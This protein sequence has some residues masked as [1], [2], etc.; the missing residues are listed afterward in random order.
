MA[1]ENLSLPTIPR[2][3]A[4]STPPDG[5]TRLTTRNGILEFS[6]Y[7]DTNEIWVPQ[8]H[9]KIFLFSKQGVLSV[10]TGK[11]RFYADFGFRIIQVRASVNTAPTGASLIVDVNKNGT[12]IFTTQA[13]RPTIAASGFTDT[14]TPD[15]DGDERDIDPGDYIQIDIDQVGSTVP[16]SDLTVQLLAY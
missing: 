15:I 4:I 10:Q 16:G 8:N 5:T 9:Q 1:R 2:S 14:G 6:V 12:T 13:N 7:D 11:S 3:S